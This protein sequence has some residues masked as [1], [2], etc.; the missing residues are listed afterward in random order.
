[1]GTALV[2]TDTFKKEKYLA[3]HAFEH[4]RNY[5]RHNIAPI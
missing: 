2:V 1:M 4:W 5:K 3:D